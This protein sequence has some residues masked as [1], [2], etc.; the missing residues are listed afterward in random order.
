MNT[1]LSKL[2][3][4][5]YRRNQTEERDLGEII[6]IYTNNY[7]YIFINMHMCVTHM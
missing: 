2:S 6:L 4:L 7:I 5:D 3:T 1:D